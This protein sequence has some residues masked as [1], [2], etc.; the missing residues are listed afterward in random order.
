[1]EAVAVENLSFTYPER[2]RK[3]LDNINLHINSGELILLCGES[4]CGKTTLLRLLK[5][6]TAPHGNLT[7]TITINGIDINEIPDSESVSQTGFVMQNPEQQIVTETVW[8]ELAFGLES[9]SLDSKIIR[10]RTAETA[11]YFGIE[12]LYH[13]D[14]ATLSG[15]EKQ[16]VNLASVMAM[17]PSILILDE[18]TSQLDPIA[19]RE[20]VSTVS[21][22][23]REWGITVIISE[24]RTEEIF[25]IADRVIIM[26]KGK[27]IHDGSPKKIGV[28]ECGKIS[29]SFPAAVRLY[30]ILGGKDEEKCPLTVRQCRSFIKNNIEENSFVIP[31]E[32]HKAS[33]DIA[34][35]LKNVC[36]RYTRD[37]RDILKNT[38]L[39]IYSGEIYT[40]LGGNGAGKSTLLRV[41]SGLQK[42][43]CGSVKILNKPIKKYP[44]NSLYVG[45][46][47]VLPQNS[48][49]LFIKS[50]LK[51]DYN[52]LKAVTQSVC[53]DFDSLLGKL[54][55]EFGITELL[56]FHPYD[57][58]GGELQKAALVKLMMLNP[59]IILLDEP[60]KGMDGFSKYDLAQLLK[61]LRKQGVTILIVTHDAEFAAVSSD[62]CGMFFDGE[63]VSEDNP[64]KFFAQNAYY[65]TSS[66]RISKGFFEDA[67]TLEH[68]CTACKENGVCNV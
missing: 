47:A 18:P 46:L 38:D 45:T 9:L 53:D 11:A 52:E 6:E 31:V 41:I 54:C 66:A 12:K 64:Q 4:G 44:S 50:S 14:T 5:K 34:I 55:D 28:S 27:V 21:R 61:G 26:E 63:I 67:V 59:K 19:A 58:S 35:E 65:T 30:G 48:Q 3:A 7:G 13:C 43:Y 33:G 57:L 62:R 56:N 10:R 40:V 51:A 20:F 37:E 68:L 29:Y 24:H 23:N 15:G 25:G 32:E 2:E 60:T 49:E 1:M 17:N 16:L 42:P 36:F 22:L 39:K 8:R